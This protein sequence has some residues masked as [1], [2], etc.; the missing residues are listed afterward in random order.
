MAQIFVRV[1]SEEMWFG[2]WAPLEAIPHPENETIFIIAE[3]DLTEDDEYEFFE[4][5]SLVQVNN[6]VDEKGRAFLG[7]VEP[8]KETNQY[9]YVEI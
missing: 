7:V 2:V 9:G 1:L 3:N 4:P 8:V 5:G 6:F